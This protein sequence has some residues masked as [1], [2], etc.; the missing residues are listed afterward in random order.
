MLVLSRKIN[1]KIIIDD[2]IVLMIIEC[3]GDKVKLGIEAPSEVR[4]FREEIYPK[5]R[6]NAELKEPDR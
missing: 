5:E 3:K 2:K 1:E 4:I 6:T